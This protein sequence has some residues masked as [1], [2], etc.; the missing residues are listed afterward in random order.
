MQRAYRPTVAIE[1][2][3]RLALRRLDEILQGGD[4]VTN[5]LLEI[6]LNVAV[7]DNAF[8]GIEVNQNQGPILSS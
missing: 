8:V 1:W 6:G 5:R 2:C 3:Q 7:T 4:N